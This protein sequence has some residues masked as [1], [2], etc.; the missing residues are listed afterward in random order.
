MAKKYN[1]NITNELKYWISDI[2]RRVGSYRR[3]KLR[4]SNRRLYGILENIVITKGTP[5]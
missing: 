3:Y 4:S 2:E 1:Y 5:I